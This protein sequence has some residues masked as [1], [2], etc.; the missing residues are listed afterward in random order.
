MNGW[1]HYCLEPTTRIKYVVSGAAVGFATASVLITV[2]ANTT[3]SIEVRLRPVVNGCG[4]RL[5]ARAANKLVRLRGTG[6]NT[7][8]QFQP[9]SSL[10]GAGFGT[11]LFPSLLPGTYLA[12]VENGFVN[13]DINWSPSAGKTVTCVAGNPDLKYRVP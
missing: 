9:T 8:D 1:V 2:N 13:G 11:A 10:P 3:T 12:Y 4:I 6:A 7:Y 5:D